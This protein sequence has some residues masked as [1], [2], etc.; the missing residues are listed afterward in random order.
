MFTP[1]VFS[2]DLARPGT[3]IQGVFCLTHLRLCSNGNAGK[4]SPVAVGYAICQHRRGYVVVL[5]FDHRIN[6]ACLAR[7][8]GQWFHICASI[9]MGDMPDIGEGRVLIYEMKRITPVP[10]PV[11]AAPPAVLGLGTVGDT[12]SDIYTNQAML[13]QHF[14]TRFKQEGQTETRQH[15]FYWLMPDNPELIRNAGDK[16]SGTPMLW[17]GELVDVELVTKT[18]DFETRA[19]PILRSIVPADAEAAAGTHTPDANQAGKREVVN[20]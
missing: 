17:T 12:Q 9:R 13:A 19:V 11:G 6:K 15:I 3:F 8:E 10:K 16:N 18:G 20:G 4:R 2:G 5:F 7:W 14:E 1:N